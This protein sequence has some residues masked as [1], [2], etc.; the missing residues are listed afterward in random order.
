VAPKDYIWDSQAAQRVK[1]QELDKLY[2]KNRSHYN[3]LAES[4]WD[5]LNDVSSEP[6][7]LKHDDLYGALRP[8]LERDSVTL[9]GMKDRDLPDPLG[10]SGPQWFSWFTHYVVE[11]YLDTLDNG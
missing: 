10:R 11:E 7:S 9:R 1:E 6:A 2:R 5:A 8:I 3:D 4:V